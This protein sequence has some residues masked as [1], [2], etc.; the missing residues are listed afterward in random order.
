M[1]EA[2][3]C[4]AGRSARDPCP[5]LDLGPSRGQAAGEHPVIPRTVRREKNPVRMYEATYIIDSTITDEEQTALIERFQRLVGEQGGTVD[6]VDKWERRRLAYEVKGKRE[7]IYVVMN[8]TGPS[9]AEAELERVLRLTDNVLRHIVVRIE[10]KKTAARAPAPTPAPA[11]AAAPR[12]EVPSET[13]ETS[14]T[15]EVPSE[16]SELIEPRVEVTS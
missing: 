9:T 3:A 11:P 7:G 12:V 1:F 6:G 5:R 16:T 4:T 14:E 15:V 13:S 2:I 10:E 8:F